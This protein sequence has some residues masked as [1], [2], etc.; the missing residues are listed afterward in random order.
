MKVTKGLIEQIRNSRI[1]PNDFKAIQVLS[2]LVIIKHDG[3]IYLYKDGT[4]DIFFKYNIS[5]KILFIEYEVMGE[6]ITKVG[7]Y[8]KKKDI[9]Y[10]TTAEYVRYINENY[11]IFD[12][13]IKEYKHDY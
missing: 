6:L 3:C 5:E 11:K 13:E 7:S 1:E 12:F 10:S 2:N 9:R 8:H 4:M